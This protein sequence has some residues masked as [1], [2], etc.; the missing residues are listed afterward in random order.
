MPPGVTD[1]TPEGAQRFKRGSMDGVV[2]LT[3]QVETSSCP[4]RPK[5]VPGNAHSL[6]LY[7]PEAFGTEERAA[8][9]KRKS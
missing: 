8:E 2:C 7:F 5:F 9:K 4:G 3:H 6:S 1:T